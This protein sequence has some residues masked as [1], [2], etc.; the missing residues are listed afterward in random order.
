MNS[1]QI[2]PDGSLGA[3]LTYFRFFFE[4][5]PEPKTQNGAKDKVLLFFF[6]E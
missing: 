1:H 6:G 4:T 3:D 2:V 5:V